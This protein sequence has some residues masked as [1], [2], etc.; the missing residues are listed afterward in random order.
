MVLNEEELLLIAPTAEA[1][2]SIF[3]GK[4]MSEYECLKEIEK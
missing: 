3:G 4:L 1:A 2:A